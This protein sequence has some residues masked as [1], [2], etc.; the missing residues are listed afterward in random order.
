MPSP[1]LL[2]SFAGGELSPS[3]YAR[4][5]LARYG[6]SLRICENF[7]VRPYGGIENR[8]GFRFVNE[9]KT[10]GR[11]VRLLPFEVSTDITYVIELGHL[12]ARF[13][14]NGARIES[15][16]IPVEVVTP[17]TEDQIAAVHFTQSADVMYLAHSAYPTRELRRLSPTSF[18]LREFKSSFGPFRPING[19]EAIKVA[20]SAALGNVTLTASAG[21]SVFSPGMVNG[22]FYL[23]AK[24]LRDVKPWEQNERNVT[25]GS[26]RRSDGKIYRVSS[27]PSLAGLTGTPYYLCGA[28]R[29]VH[30][31]GRAFDGPQDIRSDNTNQYKV[32]V[33]WEYLHANYGIVQI[34]AFNSPTS[35]SGVVVSRLPDS[36]V[37]TIGA[38]TTYNFVGNGSQTVFSIAGATHPSELDYTVTIA[39]SNVQSDPNYV[40]PSS[41]GGGAL[42]GAGS[43]NNRGGGS[44]LSRRVQQ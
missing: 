1:Y 41:S 5:D 16:G 12:Y 3:L 39:G 43:G 28:T 22:L 34:L 26:L 10:L 23:E 35:V 25:V 36:V 40:P 17:W 9:A 2:P 31:V 24:E 29:P 30:D 13:Y 11:K 42:G 38:S 33:E 14:A 8:A 32:G 20:S 44:N 21:S 27:V 15:G 19:D 7:I 37:G 4:V 18:E 6:T